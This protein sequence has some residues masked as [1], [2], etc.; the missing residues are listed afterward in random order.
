MHAEWSIVSIPSFPFFPELLKEIGPESETYFRDVSSENR[1]LKNTPIWTKAQRRSPMLLEC[2]CPGECHGAWGSGQM[3]LPFRSL[4]PLSKNSGWECFSEC[5]LPTAA[6]VRS[7]NSTPH[8]WCGTESWPIWRNSCWDALNFLVSWHVQQ[9]TV[10][11]T[12]F[13]ECQG[14]STCQLAT[15]TALLSSF[16]SKW[17]CWLADDATWKHQP[18]RPKVSE[19]SHATGID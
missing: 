12:W 5:C 10:V 15:S 14:Q 16:S 11:E 4:I 13:Y 3:E 8:C 7:I 19:T 2:W 9:V 17:L 1:T 18:L 6:S